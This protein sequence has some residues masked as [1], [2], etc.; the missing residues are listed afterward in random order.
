MGAHDADQMASNLQ[1]LQDP[2]LNDDDRAIIDRL[3]T[4]NRFKSYRE[5]RRREF[6]EIE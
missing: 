5:A 3:H 6:F 4:S 2:A 1:V